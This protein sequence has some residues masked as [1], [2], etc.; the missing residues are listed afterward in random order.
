MVNSRDFLAFD[1]ENALQVE[2]LSKDDYQEIIR[3]L[4][5]KP[6]RTELGMFGVMWSEHCC[7][8]NSRPLLS[9]FPTTGKYVV[10]GPG[11]NAGVIDVGNNQ[12]L[13]FKIESHNHPSAIEPFQGAAT[14]VGGILRD[15]FTMGARPIAVLNSLRFGNLDNPSNISLLKGVVSGISHY[16]N[17]VGVPTVGGEINFDK[18]YTGNPLVNVMALGLLETDNIVCSGAKTI[19]APV[20]YV[21]NTTGRDGVGGASFASAELTSSSLDDRPA[22]QVG[23]PFLEKSL[24]EACLEAFKSG[25]VIAA[26]DMG[27]AGITCS[28]AE[29]ASKGGLGIA[30]DLDLVPSREDDMT[31]YQYLLSESQERM[32]LVVKEEKVNNLKSEFEKWGLYANVIGNVIEKKEVIISHK[33]QV[34][35]QIP[36]SALSDQTPINLHEVIS[37]PPS[38]LQKK[39]KWKENELPVLK[40]ETSYSLKFKKDF[41]WS[42]IVLLL[43]SNPSIA[44]KKWVFQQYDYQV[45]LNTV[46]KPGESDAAVIRLRSQFDTKNHNQI[47][48]GIAASVDC[49]N[50]WVALDPYRGSVA[51]VAESARN[52]TCV[53]ALPVAITNNLNFSSP[54]DDI[55]YWQLSSSCNGISEACKILE[56]PVT[57]GNVSLYNES[58]DDQGIITPIQPT[59]VIGMV[60]IIDNAENA[61]KS[62]WK[63]TNDE[64]WLIGSKSSETTLAASSYLE[65]F[66]GHIVGRPPKINLEDEKFIQEIVRLAILS[67]LISSCHDVSDGGL[68]ISIAECCILSSKGANIFLDESGRMDNLLFSEGGSRIVFSI[69]KNKNNLWQKFLENQQNHIKSS[70]FI[71]KIGKVTNQDLNITHMD[72]L[73]CNLKMSTLTDKFNNAMTSD[74]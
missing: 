24:I 4:G 6:N 2:N 7:Y 44:S 15:I 23:D 45:Q 74:F 46:F 28:T 54:E 37:E 69:D 31:P 43:L 38:S 9:K 18:S 64:I 17:C 19:G 60:G 40:K 36:T 49:N 57:G 8:R 25:D 42:E 29:M 51:A 14:G 27:A 10:I 71:K 16:G 53:G 32:L 68:A 59:P 1:I 21:G 72:K 63:C 58:K 70:I 26:Q 35:A 33:N 11:E 66:H 67:G 55:G 52:V 48:K 34:V 61:I 30:I 56:T 5:R 3:R 39:W 62:G 50:R 73:I 22:V 47:Y 41:S 13:V 20:L 65:Y 12:K